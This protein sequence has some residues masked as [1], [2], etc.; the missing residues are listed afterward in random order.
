MLGHSLYEAN[1]PPTE[2]EIR[3]LTSYYFLNI[4]FKKFIH[5]TINIFPGFDTLAVPFDKPGNLAY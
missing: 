4:V 3:I 2:M 5:T 1:W